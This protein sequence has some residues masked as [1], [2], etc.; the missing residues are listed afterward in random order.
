MKYSIL[1]ISI[2]SISYSVWQLKGGKGGIDP[3]GCMKEFLQ[4]R[5]DIDCIDKEAVDIIIENSAG[6]AR[7][8]VR[9]L[10]SACIKSISRGVSKIETDIVNAVITELRNEY[11]RGLEKRRLDVLLA[12]EKGELIDDHNT[13]MELYHSKILL[14]YLNGDRWT[15]IN[16]IVKPLLRRK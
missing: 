14:E 15:D 10:R 8:F 5:I 6:V 3:T 7:E 1:S 11:E 16:P 2:T 13:L 4:K 12:I 9:I